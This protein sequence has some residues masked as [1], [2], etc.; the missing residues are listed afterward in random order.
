M[1]VRVLALLVLL[2]GAAAAASPAVYL[3]VVDGLD[4]RFATAERMPRL[5]ALR[6]EEPEHTSIVQ[7]QAVMPTRTNTN[8]VTLLTGVPADVHGVTG[9]A[10]WSRVADQ[11]PAKLDV[12]ELIEVETL[13]TVL[14]SE[15]PPRRSAGVFA[16]AKLAR[17]F[18]TV[19]GR[20]RAPDLLWSAD[21]LPPEQLDPATH[22]A[23]DA[24]T[25]AA[26]LAAGDDADLTVVN[27]ADVD[28]TGHG[29]GPEGPEYVQAVAGADAAIGRLVDALRARGRWAH[30]VLI[31]TAD[32]GFAAISSTV[33]FEKELGRAGISGIQLVADGGVEHV[34]AEGLAANAKDPGKTA[35]KLRR[36]AALAATTPGVAE[37]VARLPLRGVPTLARVHPDWH[38]AHP[39]AGELLLVAAPGHQLVDPYDATDASLRGNHGGPGERTVPLVVSGGWPGLI[40][41]CDAPAP[42]L[43]QVAPTIVRL[44]GIRAPRRL[45]G[46]PLDLP[47]PLPVLA[48]R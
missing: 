7:A 23:S 29:R 46:R 42:S 17:L 36:V 10:Y 35:D 33:V 44:L 26:V 12:A 27:L 1:R 24:D 39:R 43:T 20:Q 25:M 21:Q 8:H 30:T 4:A 47:P 13:F 22:Y 14:A 18:G 16:K 19:P 3:V 11:P 15:T 31:V 45:D 32:H 41:V 28:W 40:P 37:V 9:N 48:T 34:Y 38:L 6:R 2:S 5:F